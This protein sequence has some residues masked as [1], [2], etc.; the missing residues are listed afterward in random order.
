MK[1]LL[2]AVGGV[3]CMAAA[4]AHT[5]DLEAGKKASTVCSACH[6]ALGI[7]PNPAW[8][9]LAAQQQ[10]YLVKQMKDFRDGKRSDPWMSPMAA[11]LSDAEIENLAAWFNSLPLQDE[12]Q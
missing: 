7:S 8:P 10:D 11:N 3:L 5:A 4:V 12:Y 6:G 2:A 9:N 1:K